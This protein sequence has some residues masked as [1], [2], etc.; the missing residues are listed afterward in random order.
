MRNRSRAL[1][2][3]ALCLVAAAAQAWWNKDWANRK[4]IT[5]DASPTGSVSLT[6]PVTEVP[7]LV[8]LHTGN[9]AHF[10]STLENGGDLRF[11]AEDDATPLK[12][13]VER[14]DAINE[15]ALVWVKVPTVAPGAATKV[16][17]YF[18]NA[19][20]VS[21]QEPPLTFDADMGA[22][23]HF[24]E[25]AGPPQDVSANGNH[26][27]ASTALPVPASL[28]AGGVQFSGGES[29]TIAD[30]PTLAQ[31]ADTGFTFSAW[32]KT[33]AAAA[34]PAASAAPADPAAAA[35]ADA[36]AAA[37]ADAA[38]AAPA[39]AATGGDGVLFDRTGSS[40]ARLALV[41][42]GGALKA[43]TQAGGAA[44]VET[45][46][47]APVA[48]G[49]WHHV[50][51]VV[52]VARTGVYVD[53]V[54]VT[55]VDTPGFALSGD[56]S[57]GASNKG[58]AFFT[59]ELDEVELA[60]VARSADYLKVVTGA[61]GDAGTLVSVGADETEDTAGAGEGGAEAAHAS[62]FVI[63]IQ[64]V[65]GNEEAIVEQIVIGVCGV[66]AFVSFLIMIS[67][68]IMLA[69]ATAAT[70]KFLKS[71]EKLG[72]EQALDS[73]YE[74][75]KKYGKSPLFRVYRVGIDEVNKRLH[76]SA[77]AAASQTIDSKGFTTLKAAMDASM[78][79]EG[80]KLN[81]FMSLLTIAISGGPFIGLLGTVVGVMVTFGAIAATG[82][83][84]IA[85]IAPGMAAALL[86]TVAGLGVAIPSLFGYNYLG[87]VIKNVSADMHV[88]SDELLARINEAYG[89]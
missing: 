19:K 40:G 62:P 5:L 36:A 75:K 57:L 59:G 6:A 46:L 38:A 2:A 11:M 26:A 61:Q 8:R 66:M 72:G 12:F 67:K 85:A 47:S 10:L 87:G 88:F 73:L 86:A 32:V 37:P 89:E 16:R 44:A 15:I 50:A 53:G 78:V 63:I 69:G 55:G 76:A 24:G 34:D 13:H 51:L 58:D 70:A 83:V 33:G 64:A 27:S 43:I 20:A 31:A 71:F 39:V 17:M 23:Y 42:E 22:V 1:L 68:A 60:R 49:A 18:N 48:A 56:I 14:W 54:E 52:G 7:I 3:F 74:R 28:I 82:D 9:F 30:N 84:N 35:P 81:A 77:G 79:R 65:F 4:T 80:Q 45:P 25:L 41:M 21:A 29:I